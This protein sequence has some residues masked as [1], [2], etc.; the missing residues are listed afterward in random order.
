MAERGL[1]GRHVLERRSECK[2]RHES[3]HVWLVDLRPKQPRLGD[4]AGLDDFHR[5]FQER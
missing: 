3:G 4:V 1:D 5:R 2:R